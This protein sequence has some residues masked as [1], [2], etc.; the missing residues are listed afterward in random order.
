MTGSLAFLQLYK[1]YK[2][3]LANAQNGPEQKTQTNEFSK[4]EHTMVNS[5]NFFMFQYNSFIPVPG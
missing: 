3:A 2:G 4:A 5:Y 1:S